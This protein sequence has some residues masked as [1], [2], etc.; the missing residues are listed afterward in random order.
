[1]A[2]PPRPLTDYLEIAFLRGGAGEAIQVAILNLVDRGMLALNGEAVL[3]PP[4][5][6]TSHLMR[7]T[8]RAIVAAAKQPAKAATLLADRDVNSAVH[9][10][11]RPELERR[12]LLPSRTQLASRHGLWI[13]SGG[14]LAF[15]A[16]LK[17]AVAL[18]RSRSNVGFL[19]LLGLAFVVG[20]FLV[21]HP[22]RT[23]AGSAL[24]ADMT[25]LFSGLKDR[26]SSLQPRQSGND[27]AMLAAIYGVSAAYAVHPEMEQLF[28]RPSSNDGSSG[29]SSSGS[30][31]GSSCGGGGGGCG[32]CGS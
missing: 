16:G 12:G 19:V 9:A 6:P 28:P 4:L 25:T 22:R 14:A 29:D 18:A 23:A 8:E 11:C 17:I 27:V 32:G 30:S 21:T 13:L 31:C 20:T 5:Q 24:L 2:E 3:V 7:P 10:E 26:A 1:V 15:V